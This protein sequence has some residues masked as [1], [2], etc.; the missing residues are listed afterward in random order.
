M[1]GAN[2]V[3]LTIA[4][5]D[6][7]S[8]VIEGIT[9]MLSGTGVAA[10]AMGNIF[11]NVFTGTIVGAINVASSAVR[12]F[13]RLLQE[14]ANLQL[15]NITAASNY[16][17]VSGATF[18]HAQGITLDIRK[19][20]ANI[21][22]DLPGVT[23]D[24][25]ANAAS[26]L[27]DIAQA[28]KDASGAINETAFK[29]NVLE[30]TKGLTLLQATSPLLQMEDVQRFT[31][32]FFGGGTLKEL[33]QL[34]LM[35]QSATFRN[36]LTEQLGGRDLQTLSQPEKLK[37]LL[38]ALKASNL[39]ELA[40]Q[41]GQSLS[42]FWQEFISGITDPDTGLFGF[43]RDLDL[44]APGEQTI[45]ASLTGAYK[46]LFAETDSLTAAVTDLGKSLGLS[47][48]LLFLKGQIEL[49]TANVRSLS[50]FVGSIQ[51]QIKESV[52]FFDLSA[53]GS[54]GL[55]LARVT[56]DFGLWL[57]NLYWGF[58]DFLGSDNYRDFLDT[59]DIAAVGRVLSSLVNIA[60]T[61]INTF[62]DV[63][64]GDGRWIQGLGGFLN[65][66]DWGAVVKVAFNLLGV[67]IIAGFFALGSVVM[68]VLGSWLAK[69]AVAA[70]LIAFT[71]LPL[72]LI[73]AISLIVGFILGPMVGSILS[74]ILFVVT[75]G[76]FAIIQWG[77]RHT[78]GLTRSIGNAWNGLDRAVRGLFADSYKAVKSW[79]ASLLEG[80]KNFFGGILEWLGQLPMVGS[81]FSP[82]VAATSTGRAT[83]PT[84]A[85]PGRRAWWNPLS[86][87]GGGRAI[88][89]FPDGLGQV[90]GALLSEADSMLAGARAVIANSSELILNREQQGGIVQRILSGSSTFTGA[91][92]SSAPRERVV[93]KGATTV[94]IHNSFTIKS[95]KPARLQCRSYEY[96]EPAVGAV[97]AV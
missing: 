44:R 49:F 92:L 13:S 30:A 81:L 95:D 16:A 42:G 33:E 51:K 71:G 94:H 45:A 31:M 24:Y 36:K 77:N 56:Q 38:G 59:I 50:E 19:S 54:I 17:A 48:P 3:I 41:A 43:L 1:A 79:G 5:V 37:T 60:L 87:F 27:D 76:L 46:A 72:G 57:S 61:G 6:Q 28:S 7:A 78:A 88:G 86:W 63:F 55:V 4:A 97:L 90:F 96:L 39:E 70:L 14:T 47:D 65:N 40:K 89:N 23:S 2:K 29:G 53:G 22:S 58:I 73:T 18:E 93:E 83:S 74:A 75:A 12:G 10:I 84:A 62:F 64:F 35:E 68:T 91:P 66:L 20:L 52:G 82:T 32:R 34:G 25:T 85:A 15:G 11:A 26:I 21:A 80:V 9:A 67:A 69:G 8:T